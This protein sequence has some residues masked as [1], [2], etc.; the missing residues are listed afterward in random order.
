MSIVREIQLFLANETFVDVTLVCEAEEGEEEEPVLTGGHHHTRLRAHKVILS[1]SSQ[2]FATMFE[3]NPCKHPVIVLKDF[4]RWEVQALLD[5]MYS[6]QV[7]VRPGRL[8]TLLKAA[9]ALQVRNSNVISTS[10]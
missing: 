5:F 9:D 8:E 7:V 10:Q 3:E 4:Q 2:Y 6:G 1:N